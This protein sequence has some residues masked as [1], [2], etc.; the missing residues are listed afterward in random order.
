MFVSSALYNLYYYTSVF[1]NNV[2]ISVKQHFRFFI[3]IYLFSVSASFIKLY[4]RKLSYQAHTYIVYI[5]LKKNVSKTHIKTNINYELFDYFKSLS[6]ILVFLIL[7]ICNKV[8]STLIIEV[9][10]SIFLFSHHTCSLTLKKSSV[11]LKTKCSKLVIKKSFSA[12]F[13]A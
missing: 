4:V 3:F 13:T 2:E 6:A 7:V 11:V 10:K 1:V 12:V 5:I 9:Y 8:K